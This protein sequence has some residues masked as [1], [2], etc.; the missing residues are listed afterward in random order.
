MAFVYNKTMELGNLPPLNKAP[1]LET[2]LLKDRFSN[3]STS[4]VIYS[5]SLLSSQNFVNHKIKE[6][7]R[8]KLP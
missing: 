8:H 4:K 6:S 3:H 2:G 1:Y 5:F 7:C